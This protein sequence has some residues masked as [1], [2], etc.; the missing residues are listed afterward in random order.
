MPTRRRLLAFV[1]SGAAL[2]AAAITGITI[3]ADDE[4]EG[5]GF[6]VIRYGAESCARCG[7]IIDEVRFAGARSG[8][9]KASK[10]FDD[11]GCAAMDSV[12][13]PAAEGVRFFVHD[14]TD[15]SWLDAASATYVIADAIRSPMAYGL[16]AAATRVAA[17]KLASDLGGSVYEWAELPGHLPRKH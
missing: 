1:G 15:E 16:A 4:D 3:V 9:G 14:Y 7:M 10:H 17:E 2:G 11:I 12:D 6:P 8:P 5:D 13:D